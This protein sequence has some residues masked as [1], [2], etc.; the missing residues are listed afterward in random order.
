MDFGGL[1]SLKGPKGLATTA[2]DGIFGGRCIMSGRHITLRQIPK[3]K[4][5][6][7][8]FQRFKMLQESNKKKKCKKLFLKC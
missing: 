2:L 3:N 4:L 1:Q 8:I 5:I 6:T 7:L